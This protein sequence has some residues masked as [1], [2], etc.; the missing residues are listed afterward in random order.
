MTGLGNFSHIVADLDKSLAFYHEVLG[1][2]L[3]APP[4][5]FDPNLTIMKI[6]QH[7]GS[8]VARAAVEGAWRR[9]GRGDYRI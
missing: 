2:E 4:R 7:A 9:G 6:R 5:P 8:A 3:V 1:L